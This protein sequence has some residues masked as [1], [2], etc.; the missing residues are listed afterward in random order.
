MTEQRLLTCLAR[1][2]EG[3]TYA[4]LWQAAWNHATP[5]DLPLIQ[6]TLNNLRRKVGADHLHTLRGRGYRLQ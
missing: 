3:A 2:P 4:D 5:P 1:R 6:R